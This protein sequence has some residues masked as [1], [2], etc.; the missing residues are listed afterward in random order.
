MRYLVI[1]IGT[2]LAVLFILML[3]KGKNFLYMVQGLDSNKYPLSELYVVGM[4]WS[5]TK[6]L[7]FQGK[8]AADLVNQASMLY[9]PQYAQYY[10][11]I[12]WAQSITLGHLFLTLTFLLAGIMYSS[13]G[14]ILLV[15]IFMSVLCVV[16]YLQDM[17]NSLSKRTEACEMELAEVVSTMAILVNSGMVLRD[18][19]VLISQNGQGPFYELM[20]KATNNMY[21]GYSDADA[22]Y[23]F[24]RD[25]N[26]VEIK[27]FTSTLIQSMEK[28]GSE[29]A[30]FLTNESAELWNTKR[31]KMLQAGEKAATK[32]LLP[33]MLIFVGV[34]IIVISAAFS[35]SL[36]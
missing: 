32:L 24:G 23:L 25:S 33:I 16:N 1:L 15:G 28:G 30:T 20:R 2:V 7:P 3:H 22:I 5:R 27:K 9:E 14:M 12:A 8:M 21:N 13:S 17:K 36:F 18:V 34:I 26:S 29:L 11:N 35:G 6:L 19:W 10:G 4:A 31:Q